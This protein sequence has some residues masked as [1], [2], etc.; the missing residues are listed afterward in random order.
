MAD[1]PVDSVQYHAVCHISVIWLNGLLRA[2]VLTHIHIIRSCHLWPRQTAWKPQLINSCTYHGATA[3]VFLTDCWCHP[4][5]LPDDRSLPGTGWL[6]TGRTVCVS[7]VSSP[8]HRDQRTSWAPAVSS[9]CR[10]NTCKQESTSHD[11]I[12]VSA[13]DCL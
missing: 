8:C 13:Q 11:A 10:L 2:T 1:I 5:P 4:P 3:H 6:L 7:T 9:Y 12:L